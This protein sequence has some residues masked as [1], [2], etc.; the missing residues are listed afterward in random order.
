MA[1][2]HEYY[3]LHKENKGDSFTVKGYGEHEKHSVCYGLT[4]IVFL[5]SFDTEAEAREAFPQLPNDGS[6]WGNKFFDRELTRMP[7][8]APVWF[9]ESAA[10]ERW[11]EDDY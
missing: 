3:K 11:G 6:E 2:E 8:R 7:D 1:Q 10:G 9:D 4:R 5:G